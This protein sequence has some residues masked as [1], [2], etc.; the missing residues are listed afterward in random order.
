MDEVFETIN[1][2]KDKKLTKTETTLLAGIQTLQQRLDEICD[3]LEVSN[4]QLEV[5]TCSQCKMRHP[6]RYLLKDGKELI[7]THCSLQNVSEQAQ[8]FVD[9]VADTGRPN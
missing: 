5:Q 3:A 6:V 1:S 2:L 4:N 7:C 9:A 8:D